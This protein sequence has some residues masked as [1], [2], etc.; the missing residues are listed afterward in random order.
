MKYRKGPYP[1]PASTKQWAANIVVPL[2]ATVSGELTA[3]KSGAPIGACGLPGTI[4]DVWFSLGQSGKDDTNTLSMTVDVKLNGST[5]LTTK[6]IIAHVS[7]EASQQK[8]TK[9]STDTGVTQSVLNTNT[10]VAQGDILTFDMILTR[11]ATP[12]TEIKTM[13]VVVEF[14]PV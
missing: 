9:T 10:A 2:A 3:N 11:T 5:V 7:G 12:T 13:A 4:S 6:P 8:T 14:E 1:T